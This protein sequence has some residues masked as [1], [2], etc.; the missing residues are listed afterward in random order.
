LS[1]VCIVIPFYKTSLTHYEE[2]SLSQC[3]RI[4]GK[5]PIKILQPQSL[6]LTFLQERLPKISFE[7][8]D[9]KYFKSTA[10]Y[11]ELMLSSE[12]YERFLAYEYMLIYQLDA[13]VFKDELD[14]WCKQGYDYIGAP[15][16][17]EI[18][19]DS[20]LK[21]M[22]WNLKKKIA[23]WFDLKEE[24]YGNYGPME[25]I[26]KRSVGNGGFSLRKVAKMLKMVKEHSQTVEKYLSNTSPFYNEDMFFCIEM[27]RYLQRVKIPNWREALKF[28][29]EHKPQKAFQL[30]GG[31]PFGCH[32]WDIYETD[33]WKNHFR[34]FG[35]EF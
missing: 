11:N 22:I 27:N 7:K 24:R 6:N 1:N 13:F 35:Y 25:I 15:W 23:L 12:F 28:A 19:F 31:L 2:I 34:P 16:R 5:Y 20:I 29:V 10:T 26:I 18:E 4:L 3:F 21:E 32:A 14:Y 9:D 33:F 17:I 30:N 8:F